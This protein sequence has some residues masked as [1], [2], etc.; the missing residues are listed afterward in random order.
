MI[1]LETA[2]TFENPVDRSALQIEMDTDGYSL[3]IFEADGTAATINIDRE[4][5]PRMAH[6]LNNILIM[7]Q[8]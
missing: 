2:L 4:S 7:E 1:K 5:L 8:N 3:T 6:F